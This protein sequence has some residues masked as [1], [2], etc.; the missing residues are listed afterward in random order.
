MRAFRIAAAGASALT[1]VKPDGGAGADLPRASAP[2]RN[3]RGAQQPESLGGDH[4]DGNPADQW[5]M[6]ALGVERRQE[7]AGREPVENFPRNTAGNIDAAGRE[8]FQ[9]HVSGFGA[10]YR[11]K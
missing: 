1:I 2:Q 5:R 10:Q 9:C 7:A 3:Q 11:C 4:M 6:R 8:E